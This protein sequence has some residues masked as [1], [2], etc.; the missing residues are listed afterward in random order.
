MRAAG[1]DS[2]TWMTIIT[3]AAPI[4]SAIAVAVISQQTNIRL[5]DL[6]RETT[7]SAT[8]VEQSKVREQQDTRRQKFIVDHLPKLL[9]SNEAE[10]RLGRA[11][12]FLNYPNEAADILKLVLPAVIDAARPSFEAVQQE[13][14]AVQRATGDWAI[15]VSGDKTFGPAKWEVDRAVRLGYKPV[16][17]YSREGFYRTA[18]G[19]Y[20]TRQLA[21]QAAIAI[22]AQTRPDA[23]VVA[24][25]TWCPSPTTRE[26]GGLQVTECVRR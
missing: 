1:G 8:A 5:A 24:L 23:Y 21:E 16:S 18:V 3:I 15:V 19:N 17:L 4:L 13:A 25:G 11:L 6:E 20:P 22:R 2:K 9:S 7:A 12:L 14:Q 10:R 26:E